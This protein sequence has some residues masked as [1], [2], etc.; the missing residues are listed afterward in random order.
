MYL[1]NVGTSATETEPRPKACD[2]NRAAANVPSAAIANLAASKGDSTIAPI[3]CAALCDVSTTSANVD[4]SATF[5]AVTK[6]FLSMTRSLG[7]DRLGAPNL[8]GSQAAV[9]EYARDKASNVIALTF[10]V[11]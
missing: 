11:I 6:D 4:M 2:A 7:G 10:F 5:A 1:G 8:R 9:A 3:A